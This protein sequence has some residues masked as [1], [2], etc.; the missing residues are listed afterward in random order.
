[1][2][3]AVVAA[4]AAGFVAGR[5]Q[6][7]TAAAAKP[8]LDVTV[9][10][11][12]VEGSSRATF[13]LALRNTGNADA[14]MALGDTIEIRYGTRGGAGDLLAVNAQMAVT[15][16]PA[17][18]A[19]QRIQDDQQKEAG[20]RLAAQGAVTIAAGAAQVILLDGPTA[21]PGG[22]P[23]AIGL[24]VGKGVGKAPRSLALT[25]VKT[26]PVN[27]TDF[28]GDGSDGALDITANA[29]LQSLPIYTDVSIRA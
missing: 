24:K 17:G 3:L 13:F 29:N 14:V 22:A 11:I 21:S 16:L 18:L 26:P 10:P 19:L 1:M 15:M 5:P 23:V 12:Q 20:I 27:G 9:G 28:Y 6:R 7:L 4:G 25:V 2:A 8:A